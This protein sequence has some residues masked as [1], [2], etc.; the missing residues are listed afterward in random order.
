MIAISTWQIL[1]FAIQ[2]V[3]AAILFLDDSIL[4]GHIYHM[5]NNDSIIGHTVK[6]NHMSRDPKE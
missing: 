5:I 3:K 6:N 4:L 1:L 2:A